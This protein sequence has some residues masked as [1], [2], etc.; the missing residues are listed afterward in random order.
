MHK[1]SIINTGHISTLLTPS[2]T[3]FLVQSTLSKLNNFLSQTPACGGL[4]RLSSPASYSRL[5]LC[6]SPSRVLMSRSQAAWPRCAPRGLSMDCRHH[7]VTPAMPQQCSTRPLPPCQQHSCF[8]MATAGINQKPGLSCTDTA[9][10]G[11]ICRRLSSK[12]SLPA[13]KEQGF[14]YE[15]MFFILCW[16]LCDVALGGGWLEDVGGTWLPLGQLPECL[17]GDGRCEPARKGRC[18]KGGAGT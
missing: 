17:Q 15:M 12:P 18:W 2:Q 13:R 5:C 1:C 8:L 10:E 9:G 6:N 3:C 7:L 16:Q 11:H 14:F 4:K